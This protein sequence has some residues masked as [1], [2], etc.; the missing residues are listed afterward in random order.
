M[1]PITL[2][3]T[4]LLMLAFNAAQ[5]AEF[6]TL[7]QQH[8]SEA[9]IV[10]PEFKLV[11]SDE[12]EEAINSGIVITFVIQARLMD[13]VNWWFDRSISSKLQTFKLR[14]F[15]LSR[16]YELNNIS[17]K[18]IQTFVTLDLLLDHLSTKTEFQF[19]LSTNTDYIETRLFLDKQALPSTMQ[20]PIVFDPDWNINSDWQKTEIESLKVTN[21]P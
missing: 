4:V 2:L 11:L 1:K 3:T 21:N 5:A 15:S 20:L 16:Q 10:T 12:I 8:T 19:E 14:Y 13:E 6:V 18:S 7:S 17:Q 9:L